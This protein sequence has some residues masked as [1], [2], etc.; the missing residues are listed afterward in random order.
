MNIY[1]VTWVIEGDSESEWYEAPN[2]RMALVMFGAEISDYTI[3]RI[4][5]IR[6]VIETD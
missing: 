4:E 2:E 5:D 3:S 1:R 6:V